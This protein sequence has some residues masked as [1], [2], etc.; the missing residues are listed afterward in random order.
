MAQGAPPT[1]APPRGGAAAGRV[2]ARE[3]TGQTGILG[4]AG[5]EGGGRGLFPFG[6]ERRGAVHAPRKEKLTAEQEAYLDRLQAL[7]P[8]LADARRLT[9][10]F[11]GMVRNLGGAELDGWLGQAEASEVPIMRRFAAGL[12]EDLEAV[13]T[14]L[15]EEWSNGPVEA[16]STS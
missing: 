11:A 12:R 15:T 9:Q 6:Q 7:D 1:P 3:G 14:G 10:E 5:Q 8:A 4:P 16:S 2:Q 13:R